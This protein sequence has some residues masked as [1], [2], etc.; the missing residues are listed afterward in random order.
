M[1]N[2]ITPDPNASVPFLAHFSRSDLLR[3]YIGMLPKCEHVKA[4]QFCNCP[5]GVYAINSRQNECLT[6]ADALIREVD[7]LSPTSQP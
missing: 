4:H 7:A 3:A 6:L 1:K 5:I 2:R